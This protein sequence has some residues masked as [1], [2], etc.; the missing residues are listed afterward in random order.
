MHPAAHNAE[1]SMPH[2]EQVERD[3]WRREADKE[4]TR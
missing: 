4:R 1:E 2:N 3:E